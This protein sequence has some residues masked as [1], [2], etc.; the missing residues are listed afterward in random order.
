MMFHTHEEVVG[1]WVRSTN[2]EELHKVM[3]LTVYISAY[4]DG[5]FLD[6]C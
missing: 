3:E 6:D 1:I 2:S 4:C 5:A